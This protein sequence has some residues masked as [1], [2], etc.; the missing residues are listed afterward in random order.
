MYFN[1]LIPD[2]AYIGT[3]NP[4]HFEVAKMMLEHGKHVLC[5]KP[6]AMNEKQARELVGIAKKR[7][8]FLMEAI[9]SRCFPA[10]Q[11]LKKV[12]DSGVIGEVLQVNAT[13]G[14]NLQHV[15]RLK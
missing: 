7:N 6:L 8:L 1:E 15:E 4:Q 11:E 13:F 9:W 2:V 5:E 10:Y 12:L 14:F 3:L